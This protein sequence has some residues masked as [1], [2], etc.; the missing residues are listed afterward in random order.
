MARLHIVTWNC[1]MLVQFSS[2]P[3]EL[4]RDVLQWPLVSAPTSGSFRRIDRMINE[5]AL[6]DV[7]IALAEQAKT[8]HD[9]LSHVMDEVA[10]LRQT[11]QGLDPTF[12]DVLRERTA[13]LSSAQ[14]QRL[15]AQ[16]FDDLT[17]RLKDG[18]VC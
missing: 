1:G 10:A 12:S 8:Q 14:M 15:A 6:R 17:R 11:V 16:Q 9:V 4:A 5:N 2:R 18:E 3:F 7:L 13:D